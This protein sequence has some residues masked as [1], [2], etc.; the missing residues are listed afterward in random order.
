MEEIVGQ[1]FGR[2]TVTGITT[3]HNYMKRVTVVCECGTEKIVFVRSLKTGATKSCGCINKERG[4]GTHG[5]RKHPLY[6]V[7]CG[8]KDRCSNPNVHS[9]KDYGGGGVI[10]FKH[11]KIFFRKS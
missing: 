2:L 5:K 10:G 6:I 8:L 1:K 11:M 7:W 9:Y 4:R 3:H